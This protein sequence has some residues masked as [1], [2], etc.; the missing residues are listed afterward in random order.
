[1]RTEI[2]RLQLNLGTTTLFVTHDQVEAMTMATRIA[3]M[4]G[5]RI[6][7]VGAPRAIYDRPESLCV[8]GF[9]GAP[10]MNI[11]QGRIV[12]RGPAVA[13]EVAGLPLP[14]GAYGWREP[15]EDGRAVMLGLRAEDIGLPPAAGSFAAE[16]TPVLLQPTGADTTGPCWSGWGGGTRSPRSSPP[17]SSPAPRARPG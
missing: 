3:V 4:R 7:Q 8:A 15:P 11:L 16:A 12:R 14:L 6:L 5:G 2:E 17:R 13:V 10:G 9:V 1:M